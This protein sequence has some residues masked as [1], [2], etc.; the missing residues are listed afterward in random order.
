MAEQ[1]TAGAL[2]WG[3]RVSCGHHTILAPGIAEVDTRSIRYL[4][5]ERETAATAIAQALREQITELTDQL[6][7]AE[8]ELADLATTRKTL[9]ALTGEPEA[10][11][12]A[13]ATVATVAYQQILAVFTTTTGPMRAKDVCL[14]LGLGTAP[15]DAEG[16][17]AKLKR[18][19]ARHVLIE[20]EPGLFA[21]AATT[22]STQD[23]DQE[24]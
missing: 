7:R 19:V 22:P 2:T 13:D 16:L 6:T 4:I 3:S 9:N 21:L 5:G 20:T 12:P 10:T 11:E 24:R 14:A 8:T 15:K 1:R 23:R 18:L 17:R